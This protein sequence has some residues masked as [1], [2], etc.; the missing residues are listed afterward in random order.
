[1]WKTSAELK[2]LF[3]NVNNSLQ[4]SPEEMLNYL[5]KFRKAVS[6]I[7]YEDASYIGAINATVIYE[8][9]GACGVDHAISHE[10]KCDG[11]HIIWGSC[12]GGDIQDIPCAPKEEMLYF[13]KPLQLNEFILIFINPTLNNEESKAFTKKC[14]SFFDSGFRERKFMGP[15]I[16]NKN[17][18]FKTIADSLLVDKRFCASI[19]L[20]ASS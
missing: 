3:S 9:Y 4:A 11:I 15:F 7:A 5:L 16:L 8:N 14:S 19:Y 12:G 17:P 18:H 1:M 2:E 13:I 20:G 10:S 6:F